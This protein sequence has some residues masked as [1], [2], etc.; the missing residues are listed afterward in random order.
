MENNEHRN[1]KSN[2]KVFFGWLACVLI[3]TIV[4]VTLGIAIVKPILNHI[5]KQELAQIAEAIDESRKQQA[6]ETLCGL[7]GRVKEIEYISWFHASNTPEMKEVLLLHL[8]D[9]A[10]NQKFHNEFLNDFKMTITAS[11]IGDIC[12]ELTSQIDEKIHTLKYGT[13]DA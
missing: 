9:I 2:V 8:E 4:G 7:K 12:D 6:V 13:G 1:T 11:E 3:G 5:Q 10:N